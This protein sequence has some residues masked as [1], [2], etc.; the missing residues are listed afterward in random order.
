MKKHYKIFLLLG[1]IVL[2]IGV[3]FWQNNTR[4]IEEKRTSQSYFSSAIEEARKKEEEKRKEEEEKKRQEE[5]TKR[6]IAT[7]GPCRNIPIL[8]YH[9]IGEDTNWLFVKKE[10]FTSQMDYLVQK[11]YQTVTLIDL[12]ASLQSGQ[13]LPSKPVV[14]TFDDGYRDFYQNAYPILKTHNFKATLFVISQHV[15]G[16]EYVTWEQ[17]RE[18]IGSGLVTVGDHTL[19]HPSLPIL[20][21]ERLKDEVISA[22]NILEAQ[23][24]T[25]INVFSY[26]YG[27][28]NGEVE[29][30][31]KESGFIAAVTT[32]RGLSCAK[33]PYEL[34]RIRIGNSPLSNYGL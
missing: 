10:T 20:S 6:F 19:S 22:K 25:T 14:L 7:Y 18:M 9:H 3:A 21:E 28:S 26:P 17:L 4:K 32:K 8:M 23:L 13:S 16:S 34:P 11:G 27:G 2:L 12:V 33:L 29:K 31:L 15:G 24:G 5:E 1:G 30:I